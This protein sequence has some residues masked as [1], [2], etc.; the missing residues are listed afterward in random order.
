MTTL[1]V[2]VALLAGIYIGWR[3]KEV[4]LE[5]RAEREKQFKNAVL[6]EVE[7]QRQKGSVQ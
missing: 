3:F 5:E 7:I 4:A 2:L 6:R 1:F